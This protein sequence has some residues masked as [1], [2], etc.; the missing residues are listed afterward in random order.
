MRHIT[1]MVWELAGRPDPPGTVR[2]EDNDAVCV[3]C[4]R[5]VQRSALAAKAIGANFTDQALYRRPDSTRICPACVWCCSGRGLATLRLWSVAAA[6]GIDVGASQP[7]AWLQNLPGLCL[8]SRADPA[9]V[10]DL[11]LT[12]PPGEWAVSVA[13]SGQKHVLPYARVNR[14]GGLWTVRLENTDITSTPTQWRT[15]LGHTAALRAA[16][17]GAEQVRDGSP[18]VRAVKT[19][20]DLQTWRAL[21]VGLL[22]YLRSPLL[23][24]A[25]WCCTKTTTDRYAQ[26]LK[27]S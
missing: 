13:T 24:L 5:A 9:P 2:F 20:A 26:L 14:G 19:P 25:L 23:D 12:P 21:A 8:T 16:G 1:V 11:L 15:V 22:P 17:H 7:K 6:P 4:G 18:D 27:E 10:A 3:M